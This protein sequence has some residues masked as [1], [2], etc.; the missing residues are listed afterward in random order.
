MR[1]PIL[2]LLEVSADFTEF[3][4]ENY[5]PFSKREVM[6]TVAVPKNALIQTL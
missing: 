5:H 2:P 3:R 1:T 4:E 6:A